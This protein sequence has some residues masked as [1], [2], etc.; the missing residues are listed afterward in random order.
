MDGLVRSKQI[1]ESRRSGIQFEVLAMARHAQVCSYG[2]VVYQ[3]LTATEDAPAG[4]T[5]VLDEDI[6][7][8]R[9]VNIENK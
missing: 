1:W 6:F 2:M 5:W 4:T 3:N 8:K 7:I 9:M